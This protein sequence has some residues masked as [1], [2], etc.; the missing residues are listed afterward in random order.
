MPFTP[1]TGL[2]L[3]DDAATVW[4]YLDLWKFQRI[5][6]TSGLY[7]VRSDRFSDPCDS[8]LPPQWRDNMQQDMCG[9]GKY[10]EATWYEKREIPANPIYCFNCEENESEHMWREY[11]NGTDALVIRSTVGRLKECFSST[12]VEV[13]IGRVDY[14][15]HDKLDEPQF[16]TTDWG[17]D[18]PAANLKNPWYVPRYYFKRLKFAYEKEVRASIHVSQPIDSGYNLVIGSSGIYTLVESIH[19]HPSATTSLREHLK[20]L[21]DQYGFRDIPLK[22]STLR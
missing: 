2:E 1:M 12:P 11:T 17:D 5:L 7:F 14:G 19:M 13:R 4:R 18:E 15:Y 6:E 16:V 21:L 9:D 22:S 3:P 8:V 10:T 20:S